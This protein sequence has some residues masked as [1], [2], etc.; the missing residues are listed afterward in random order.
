MHNYKLDEGKYTIVYEERSDN[1]THILRHNK[2]WVE[3][4]DII[5]INVFN[6]LFW[7]VLE[8]E[9]QLLDIE[10]NKEVN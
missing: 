1:I 2:S 9:Q 3:S 5:P 8:L 10:L 4:K 6:L 7:R